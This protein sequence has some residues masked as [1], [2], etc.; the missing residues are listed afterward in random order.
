M[1]SAAF[2]LKRRILCCSEQLDWDR[3]GNEWD[4]YVTKG[5]TRALKTTQATDRCVYR[6]WWKN[7]QDS[8][9]L[10][11][12]L[13]SPWNVML[14]SAFAPVA[15]PNSPGAG[16]FTVLKSLYQSKNLILPTIRALLSLSCEISDVTNSDKQF[17]YRQCRL[18]TKPKYSCQMFLWQ[19]KKNKI[20]KFSYME[21]LVYSEKLILSVFFTFLK[22][23]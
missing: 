15:S 2:L 9:I 8:H 17:A 4:G 16:L 10:Y 19:S 21:K 6:N 7:R 1:K 23:K 22:L 18:T 12:Q 14:S 20:S 3:G 5:C 13:S 11:A